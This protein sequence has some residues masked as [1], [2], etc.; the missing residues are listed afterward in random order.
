MQATQTAPAASAPAEAS[1][2]HLPVGIFGASMGVFG[3]ALALRAAGLA[4]SSAAVQW[5]GIAFFLLLAV[6]Y[7]AKA[8]RHPADVKA[9]WNHPVRM[10]FFPAIS[11]SVLLMATLLVEHRP[12][13]AAVL[14]TVG[15]A[16]HGAL[17]VLVVTAWI[18]HR[19][20][21]PMHLSP[22]W[23]IPAVGN[24]IVPLA[25][26]RLGYPE[27]S[28]YFLSVGLVFWVVLLTIVFNR[29]IFHD[30][31]PGRL[32]PTLVILVAPPAVAF[33]AWLQL[34]GGAV[35]DFAR[36]L[37]N[38]GYVF[39]LIVALQ[40]PAI[41]RLPF[42]LS[43]WALS[44][45]LA[46]IATASF[47]FAGLTGST[48]HLWAGYA[49]LAALTLAILGLAVKTVQATLAGHVFRPE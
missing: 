6:T 37:L 22:A 27:V 30:P 35:D 14:W 25:G 33:L 15:A 49:L 18:G 39:A 20:F 7:A 38:V 47:R 17:T 5:A 31:M 43:F 36:I 26:V 9:E 44:F 11:I 46:A 19:P 4:H 8:I 1:L 32:R 29:L 10:A 23:F 45:P 13:V 2:R 42:S 40:A 28:W 24:V 3:F 34:H 21:Q 12:G 41:L 48:F 16:A